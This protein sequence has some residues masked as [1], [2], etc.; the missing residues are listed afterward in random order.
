MALVEVSGH[1]VCEMHLCCP[2]LGAWQGKFVVDSIDE[3]SG[4]VTISIW[5]GRQVLQG[6]VWRGAE[7]VET[8]FLSIV[9]GAGGL[10]RAARARHYRTTSA[11]IVLGDLL[12][13][14]SEKLS[15]TADTATL[16]K[17]LPAWTTF[18]LPVG[19]ILT[20]V[21]DSI[22]PSLVWRVLPDG[23]VWVGPETWPDSGL[24]PDDYQILDEDP[25][26]NSAVLGVE[27]P[28]LLPG[29]TLAGRRVSY[30]EHVIDGAGVRT[31]VWFE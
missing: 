8:S 30:V 29:T 31:V 4:P 11:K 5:D 28:L 17:Q 21:L 24:T 19:R 6:F 27:A 10:G 14:A 23:T 15:P 2:R 16:A 18:A 12:T 9:G 25:R 13:G 22:T 7:Y 26:Q 3:I 1:G 20:R